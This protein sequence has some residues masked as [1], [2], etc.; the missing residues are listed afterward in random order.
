M[1]FYTKLISK[2]DP[3]SNLPIF[4]AIQIQLACQA[5]QDAEKTSECKHLLHLVPRWQDPV[6]VYYLAFLYT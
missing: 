4:K 3:I 6:I 1:N 5:C 2:I